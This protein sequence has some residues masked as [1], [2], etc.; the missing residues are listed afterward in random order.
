M[1]DAIRKGSGVD[2]LSNSKVT[3][4]ALAYDRIMTLAFGYVKDYKII[5]QGF[6]K[7]GFYAVE[8]EATVD[9]GKPDMTEKLALRNIVKLKGS[10]KVAI[11][12]EVSF[13]GAKMD[14]ST[15]ESILKEMALEASMLVVNAEKARENAKILSRRENSLGENK[16]AL[17]RKIDSE[18]VGDFL[19]KAKVSGTFNGKEKVYGIEM[20][21]F[22]FDVSLEAVWMDTAETIVQENLQGVSAY[23]SVISPDQAARESLMRVLTGRVP[24]TKN[25]S[26]LSFFS[27]IFA[28]WLTDIDLGS[29]IQLEFKEINEK[30][31]TKLEKTLR[32]TVGVGSVLLRKFD[33]RGISELEIESRLNAE[34]IKDIVLKSLDGF[35]LDRRTRNY[36]QFTPKDKHEPLVRFKV[37]YLLLACAGILLLSIM[38]IIFRRKKRIK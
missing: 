12:A 18:N 25:N 13:N 9:K 36:L 5:S 33:S 4:Y 22:S 16:D 7:N 17:L 6:D 15:V 27:K 31:L 38:G 2:I 30:S 10:P 3:D 34:T 29:R 11:E 23:S 1:R 21:S 24:K 35:K 14:K 37:K 32:D 26:A 19:I 28:E 8:I 20:N